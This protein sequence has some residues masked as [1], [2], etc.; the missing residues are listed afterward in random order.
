MYR[1]ETTAGNP[2]QKLGV[3][4][5]FDTRSIIGM[6]LVVTML[7]LGIHVQDLSLTSI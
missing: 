6:L 2:P 3:N 1:T 4:L 7:S 5:P